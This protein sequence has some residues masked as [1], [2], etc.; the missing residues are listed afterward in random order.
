LDH[1]KP[2]IGKNATADLL[3]QPDD[4]GDHQT[5][6]TGSGTDLKGQ[7]MPREIRALTITDIST[8]TKI[9][10]KDLVERQQIPSH[11]AMLTLISKAAGYDNYQHLKATKPTPNPT[12]KRF[13][14][15]MRVF[16]D[17]GTMVRWPK[18][19]AVQALCLWPFWA[20]LPAKSDL[21]EKAVNDHL[22]ARHSFGDHALLRRSLVDHKLVRRTPDG[23]VYRRIEKA[24]PP[25]ALAFIAT[26]QRPS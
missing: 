2:D 25:E 5:Q 24:P 20:T 6:T 1:A 22:N 12:S 15:A 11:A 19:T 9:L 4:N 7:T 26:L 17:T 18:K 3:N 8:F 16:D 13:E 21:S 23:K 10:R 14:R